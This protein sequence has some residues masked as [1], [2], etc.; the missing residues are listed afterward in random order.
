VWGWQREGTAV[1]GAT[2][3]GGGTCLV[4]C[5]CVY[6]CVLSA[7]ASMKNSFAG[8]GNSCKPQH[9]AG[10]R[11]RAHSHS[12]TQTHTHLSEPKG[13]DL[14]DRACSFA[15]NSASRASAASC[16]RIAG[17]PGACVVKRDTDRVCIR[18]YVCVCVCVCACVRVYVC[19]CVCVCVCV[20]TCMWLAQRH[21]GWVGA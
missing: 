5:V 21:A 15:S 2:S 7:Q 6:V 16:Q 12:H 8:V 1:R 20:Y 14:T 9:S 4:M 13:S 11:A 18:V 3:S 19:A 10:T 17:C